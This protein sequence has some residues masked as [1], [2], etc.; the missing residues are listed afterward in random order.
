MVRKKRR[1]ISQVRT[2]ESSPIN[3]SLKTFA[4]YRRRHWQLFDPETGK[5]IITPKIEEGTFLVRVP[6][7]LLRPNS[8]YRRIL[9]LLSNLE[10]RAETSR[11]ITDKFNSVYRTTKSSTAI[12]ARLSELY[13]MGLVTRHKMHGDKGKVLYSSQLNLDINNGEELFKLAA[14]NQKP[15][16]ESASQNYEASETQT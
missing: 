5:P 9:T 6:L 3:N 13:A 15:G 11:Y 7:A 8:D 16:Q 10:D 14:E 1:M 12:S 2:E 4:G